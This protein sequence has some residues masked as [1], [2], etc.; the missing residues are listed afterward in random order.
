MLC[1]VMLCYEI[2]RGTVT[3]SFGSMVSFG[4]VCDIQISNV[5]LQYLVVSLALLHDPMA[6]YVLLAGFHAVLS[7]HRKSVR[8]RAFDTSLD[9]NCKPGR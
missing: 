6:S 9:V 4:M 3:I 5:L 7:T 1:H 8:L 2:L